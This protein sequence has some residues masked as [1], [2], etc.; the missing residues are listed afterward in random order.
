MKLSIGTKIGAGYALAVVAL[1]VLGL[2]SFNSVQKFLQTNDTVYQ[3][4]LVNREVDKL[5]VDLLNM[6]TGQR[7]FNITGNPAFLEPYNNSV[8]KINPGLQRVRK[9][10]ADKELLELL[11]DLEP[12]VKARL[13]RSREQVALQRRLGKEAAAK[14]TA[15]GEGKNLMDSIREV[16]DKMHEREAAILAQRFSASKAD[17]SNLIGIVKYG[18]P[19]AVVLLSLLGVAI[20]RNISLPLRQLTQAAD[21]IAAGNLSATVVGLH[22]SDELGLLAQAFSRMIRALQNTANTAQQVAAGNLAVSI[23]PQ[24]DKDVIASALSTMVANLSRLIGQVQKSGIQVNTSTTEIAAMARQQQATAGE[25]SAT[26]SEI[27]ATSREI[28]ATSRELVKSMKVVGT[29]AEETASLA[30]EGQAGLVRMQG[31][32]SQIVEASGSITARLAVLNEKATNINTVVTTITKVADQTNLLSLNAAIEAEKAGEY[33]RGFAVV[34]TEIRRL[35]DQTAVATADIEQIVK[36]MQSAVSAGIMGMDKFSEEVRRGVAEVA[37]VGEQLVQV[38]QQV[39]A[40]TPSFEMVNEGMQSQAVGAEQISEALGQLSEAAQQTVESL[41]QSNQAIEQL[42]DATRGLQ[43][44]V[45][46]FTLQS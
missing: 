13:E 2:T 20:V 5:V 40:L 27:G 32:M 16:V 7:G 46:R 38:V 43:D 31:T 14:R 44:G 23:V 41:R 29:A 28:S 15:A 26:T 39:Q 42:N 1:V 24:S 6:E 12:L 35:A 18:V 19:L 33:G 10:V 34:A 8:G 11:D 45:S 22:R 9:L 36:E 37:Q 17:A 4:F 3:T 25:I 30:S 21:T